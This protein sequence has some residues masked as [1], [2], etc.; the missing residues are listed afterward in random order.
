MAGLHRKLPKRGPDEGVLS[1]ARPAALRPP[2]ADWLDRPRAAG[3]ADKV[4]GV[5]GVSAG[6]APRAVRRAGALLGSY[7]REGACLL[8]NK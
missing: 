4:P 7:A 2:R 8:Q 3:G 6:P 5:L 1:V